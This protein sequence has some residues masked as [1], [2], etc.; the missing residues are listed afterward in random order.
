MTIEEAAQTLTDHLRGKP[1]FTAV[2][3]GEYEG[4]PCLFLYVKAIKDAEL[5]F[6]Q[7][8]WHGFHVEVRRMGTP[9]ILSVNG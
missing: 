1:W 6:L 2:G 8:G 4:K 7:Q 5:Q 9:R 3:I